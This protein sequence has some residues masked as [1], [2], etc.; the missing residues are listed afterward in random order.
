MLEPTSTRLRAQPVETPPVDTSPVDTSRMET[1]RPRVSFD[2]VL[3]AMEA[4][5]DVLPP[6]PAWTYPLLDAATGT[7]VVVKHENVQPTGSFKVRGGINLAATLTQDERAAG[8]VTASTGNH[9]QSVAFAGRRLGVPVIIVMPMSAPAKK[10]D[11]TRLLGAEVVLHGDGMTEAVAHAREIEGLRGMRYVDPG[12]DPAIV[13]GHATVYLEL[14]RQYP[15][16]EAIYVPVGS[17]SG[18]A[19]A[20]IVRD[21]VAPDCRIIA[22]QSQAAP[23]A[24]ESWASRTLAV[25]EIKTAYSGL[26]TG[27]GFEL[28]QSV[29]TERLDDFLL[30]SEQVIADAIRLLATDAH[31]LAEGAGAASLAGLLADDSRP[32]RCAVICTGG[33]A[34]TTELAAISNG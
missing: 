30:V 1:P 24:Y 28:P 29:L 13:H 27:K 4:L 12:N 9:A 5:T 3:A 7:T 14:L 19:G 34:D 31:T 21:A 6:T 10:I 18:A 11:A 17:G 25:A 16:L 23:A 2:G 20:C 33:N 22:V 26:A 15:D 8:L 32:S